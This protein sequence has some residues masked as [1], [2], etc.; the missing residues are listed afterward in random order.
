VAR[1]SSEDWKEIAHETLACEWAHDHG[2]LHPKLQH[3]GSTGWPD[4]CF[5]KNGRC[6][7]IEFKKP[8][9]GR[10]SPKQIYWVNEIRAHGGLAAFCKT[11]EEAIAI[12][13]DY[14]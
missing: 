2:W 1:A 9:G 14:D 13:K 8:K 12:L 4:R 10:R 5:I 11:A 6:I 7:F 3:I